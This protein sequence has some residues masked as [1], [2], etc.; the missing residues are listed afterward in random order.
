M[1]WRGHLRVTDVCALH[2]WDSMMGRVGGRPPQLWAETGPVQKRPRVGGGHPLLFSIASQKNPLTQGRGRGAILLRS[3]GS[4]L[5]V[6]KVF[7]DSQRQGPW[8]ISARVLFCQVHADVPS[9]V[10]WLRTACPAP[11]NGLPWPGRKPETQ[12]GARRR[13]AIG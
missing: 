5:R 3:G 13:V 4:S 12:A 6:P 9:K 8:L 7:Q 2:V 10:S 11:Q 1:A